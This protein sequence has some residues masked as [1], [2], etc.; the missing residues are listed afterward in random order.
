MSL[1]KFTFWKCSIAA[2]IRV[3]CGLGLLCIDLV[4]VAQST[5]WVS[6]TAEIPIMKL[7]FERLQRLVEQ[8]NK[9]LS[10]LESSGLAT[11]KEAF[12]RKKVKEQF[13]Q[14][15]RSFYGNECSLVSM[16]V[17]SFYLLLADSEAGEAS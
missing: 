2:Q 10:K 9:K 5:T 11:N 13:V 14:V 1:A 4:A 3:V 17:T 16:G 6:A 8:S 7:E 12:Y 15:A